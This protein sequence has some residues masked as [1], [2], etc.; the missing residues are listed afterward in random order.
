MG[1]NDDN[2]KVIFPKMTSDMSGPLS[3]G[4][5]CR[6]MITASNSECLKGHPVAVS[7]ISQGVQVEV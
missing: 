2:V 3:P 6:V 4:D 7:S 5:Y 1:R